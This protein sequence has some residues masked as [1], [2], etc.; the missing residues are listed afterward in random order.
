MP[1]MSRGGIANRQPARRGCKLSRTH[2]ILSL[3]GLLA[4]TT[5][6]RADFLGWEG[7][8]VIRHEGKAA[9]ACAHDLD[10]D[11]R[12][13]IVLVDTRHSRLELYEWVPADERDEAEQP[14]PT[15]PN[16]LP[17]AP[18]L[19]KVEVPLEQLPQDVVARDIDGDGSVELLIL[20]SAPNRILAYNRDD[21]DKWQETDRW[22]LLPGQIGANRAAV[23]SMSTDDQTELLISF[24]EGIQRLKLAEGGRADW[25]RPRESQGRA[26]WWLV[27]LDHDGDEDLVEWT[28]KANSAVRWHERIADRL[29]PSSLLRKKAVAG[30]ALLADAERG[31]DLIFLEHVE[32][33]LLRWFV[34][35]DDD[36]GPLGLRQA[37][38]LDG[39]ERAVWC[40]LRLDGQPVLVARDDKQPRLNVTQLTADGWVHGQDYPI[41]ADVRQIAA[42]QA[43][44]GTLLLWARDASDLYVS[45]WEGG[46]LTFPKPMR[47]SPEVDDR[48]II[49]L[50]AVGNA[51]WWVQRVDKDIDLYVWHADKREPESVRFDD[52]GKKVDQALWLGATRL[53]I[54]EAYGQTSKLASIQDGKTIVSQ[55]GHIKKTQLSEFRLVAV[56]DELRPARLTDGVLQWL[57]DDLQP[58]DQVML[59]EGR[60]LTGYVALA[61]GRAWALQRQDGYVHLLAP[62]DAGIMRVDKSIDLGGGESLVEDPVLGIVL[63]DAD[64]ITRLSPGVGDKLKLLETLDSDTGRPASADD[65][66]IQRIDA[67]DVTGD[68]QEELILHDDQ[69]HQITVLER[70]D[71]QLV[72][73]LSWP[74]FEDKAYPYGYEKQQA[75]GEPRVVLALD[76]DGDRNTDL[77]MLCHD[78]LIIYLARELP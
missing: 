60:Q 37:M 24:D 74:V 27:D 75:A 3:V 58:Q 46:R 13:E 21:Q 16:E 4:A 29:L 76:V 43:Q 7:M 69:H 17:M 14:K 30:V 10:G 66:A 48:K 6:V 2:V 34:L 57:D 71:A 53:L 31:A 47:Q 61:D 56:G 70:K 19:R 35:A 65:A 33:G 12:D 73:L 5:A 9:R 40:G 44:P 39:G 64:R 50:G 1:L 11:G 51:T 54:R 38:P 28:H 26:G 18:E 20:V 23:L 62:D 15:K 41:I 55:P 72:P 8:R 25:L 32:K 78:R 63:V 45:R 42:P 68:G 77:A 22:D 52:V 36:Q 59:P 49:A 67:V